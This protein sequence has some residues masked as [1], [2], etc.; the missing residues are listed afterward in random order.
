MSAAATRHRVLCDG[1]LCNRLNALIFA[2]ILKRRFGHAWSISWPRNNW[3]GAGFDR[4]FTSALPHDEHGITHYKRAEN[5]HLLLVHENQL[6]FDESRLVLNGTLKSYA[7]YGRLLDSHPS[8]VY[9]H[10]LLPP[11]VEPGDVRGALGEL[12]LDGQVARTAADFIARH[13]IDASVLGLHIRKTDFGDRVDERALQAQAAASPR[14][15]FV[16]SDDALVN[17][18]FAALPNCAVF[19]KTSFPEKLQQDAAWLHWTSD[20]DGRR[21]PFNVSRSEASVVE[22]LVD[23]L[24]LS[25]TEVLATSGSTFLS[26]A[27]LFRAGR[28]FDAAAPGSEAIA[29]DA[30]PPVH[31]IPE[32]PVMIEAPA[33][34]RI[35]RVDTPPAALLQAPAPQPPVTQSDL[36]GLLNLIRPWQM[37]SDSKLRIG[38]DG[39][40]GYVMPASSRRSNTVLSI[41]I[42]NEVSFDDELAALGARV[43][44]FDHTIEASPSRHPNVEFHRKGWGAHDGGGFVS[45]RSMVDL[46]DWTAARHPILKFDTEGAEWS[47]LGEAASEDLARFEVLTGEFHDF[48]HLTDRGYHDRVS[49][50]FEK[51]G[52]THRVIHLHANNAGGLL[53]MG[54]VPFPRLLELTWMHKS[55]ATFHGHSSEPIPGPLD[56]P[57]VPQLPDIHLRAF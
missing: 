37:I 10:H 51:L 20:A 39:D 5:D 33:A 57:N 38:S 25:R 7:E 34:A 46:I 55:S 48:Q 40:G 32:S 30:A 4:L 9:F 50:V 52:R 43:I 27:R 23:L 54:G 19:A 2:L 47:C 15:F 18:R 36:F 35:D 12:G 31:P 26:M 29:A 1:G 24:I 45:L 22:A 16:C 41:G 14:R 3:C 6:G 11:F 42:G 28:W 13:R 17:Q 44:Q 8:A 56:R 49:S 53:M 21:F